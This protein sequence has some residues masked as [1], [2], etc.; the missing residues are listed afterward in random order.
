MMAKRAP[1]PH[2]TPAAFREAIAETLALARIY[3]EM[4]E[5]HAMIGDDTGLGYDLD[6]LVAC[7][8]SAAF[9][10]DDLKKSKIKKAEV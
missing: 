5:G 2:G 8:R 1:A 7:I 10:Y 6:K 3:A 9:V 4:A